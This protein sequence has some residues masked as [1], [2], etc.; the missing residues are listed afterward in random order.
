MKWNCLQYFVENNYNFDAT[1]TFLIEQLV[2]K[3]IYKVHFKSLK[4]FSHQAHI[5]T[6]E[7]GHC[8]TCSSGDWLVAAAPS[9][10]PLLLGPCPAL[11]VCSEERDRLRLERCRKRATSPRVTWE[12]LKNTERF[13]SVLCLEV[14]HTSALVH[15]P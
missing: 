14:H 15:R 6:L 7:E 8:N 12:F 9:A 11:P 13:C 3:Y 10:P 1:I 2:T 4:T 5:K